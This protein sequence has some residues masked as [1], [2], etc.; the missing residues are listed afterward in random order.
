[1]INYNTLLKCFFAF[2]FLLFFNDAHAQKT[3]SAKLDIIG[4]GESKSSRPN[5]PPSQVIDGNMD[6]SS[7]WSS[8][9]ENRDL[10]LDLGSN[11]H[12]NTVGIAWGYGNRRIY[13]F[14]IQT[15]K[16][17]LEAWET[18]YHGQSSGNSSDIELYDT[19]NMVAQYVRVK[20]YRNNRSNWQ[21]ITEVEVYGHQVVDRPDRKN[22]FGN[23]DKLNSSQSTEINILGAAAVGSHPV[24]PPSK[25]IDGHI[26]F[27]SKWSGHDRPEEIIFD[28][29]ADY[30]VDNIFIA[31][32]IGDKKRYNFEVAGRASGVLDWT[33]IYTGTSSG[34]STDLENYS[35]NNIT[36]NQIRIRGLFDG[37]YT[38]ISEV[39]LY[40][41]G[42][43]GEFGL[44]PNAE[45]WDNFDLQDWVVDTPA[46]ADDGES[47]RYGENDWTDI[48]NE[49]RQFF[50]THTD[51]GMRFKTRIDGAKTSQNTSYVR[52]EL[53]EMLRRGNTSINTQGVNENNWALGYQPTGSDHGGRNGLLTA[54]LR[55]NQV[56]TTGTGIHVGRTI[57]GQI[58]ADSDE[59]IRLYYRKKQSD[60]YG[61]IY[62]AHEI[63]NGDDIDFDII[64]NEDCNNPADGIELDELFSYEIENID[65]DILV[66]IRRGD[67]D[68]PLIGQTTIDMQQLNSG[69]DRADEWMYFKAG[70][71]TQN[72]TGNNDD[73]DIVTFYRLSNTHDAN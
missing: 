6:R 65:E 12:V 60:Q 39:K 48:S 52:S 8:L 43:A 64:G 13:I 29:G 20:V 66:R 24:F 57:I 27:A 4:T 22:A 67:R 46:F 42:G 15:R 11:H 45:P 23:L 61:C 50:F 3:I 68:G 41:T 55:V 1:M 33:T 70:A 16:N 59:P 5:F 51:G 25:A 10:W 32:A 58:H 63:R 26:S 18:V 21:N 56:T 35:V 36:A 31:W 19:Q 17:L 40:G 53:R 30:S 54:T 38:H 9:G 47:Q 44:N 34:T 72:S 28:L 14:E 71:Y 62:A 69:Y 2:I 7:R 37:A 73:G 49:S